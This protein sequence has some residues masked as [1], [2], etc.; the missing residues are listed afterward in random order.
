[1]S[2]EW[3]ETVV[4]GG[5]QGGLAVGYH[6]ARQGREFVILE[7]AGRVGEAWRG[8]WDSLRLF[9]PAGT[10]GLPGMPFPA[11]WAYCPGKDEMA[12]YLA[13]YAARFNLPVRLG[14]SVDRLTRSGSQYLLEVGSSRIAARNVVV[15][16]GLSRRPYTPT[17]AAELAPAILQLS[18]NDYRKPQQLPHGSVLVVGA[19]NSGAEIA[20]DLAATGR[21][22]V[23]SG[24]DPGR[25]PGATWICQ[26]DSSAPG[27]NLLGGISWRFA[28]WLVT[29]AL[30]ADTRLGRKIMGRRRGGTPLIRLTASDLAKSGVQRAPRTAGVKHGRPLL[31]DGRALDVDAVIW[32]TGYQPDFGWIE[33]PVCGADGWPIHHRGVVI[34]EPGLYFVGL[35]FQQTLISEMIAGEAYDAAHVAELI[36]E[37]QERAAA[38]TGCLSVAS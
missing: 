8:R 4:V 25:I 6:L 26:N 16:T 12:D 28:W 10:D 13:A 5:G 37:R 21:R 9:S 29:R 18:T 2:V 7:A 20:V 33:L 34:E 24:R 14:A 32:A 17:F 19:G 23:L 30:T 15:A 38:S 35:P 27:R 11:P 3:F 36:S 1:M 31:E 22:V